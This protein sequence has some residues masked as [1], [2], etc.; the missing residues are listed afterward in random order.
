MVVFGFAKHGTFAQRGPNSI[1]K[2]TSVKRPLQPR[3]IGARLWVWLGLLLPGGCASGPSGDGTNR[4]KPTR[5]LPRIK[6]TEDGRGF[7]AAKSGRVFRPWGVNYGNAGRL[8]EDF[9]DKDWETFAGDFREMRAM[10]FNVV[11]V[12][13]Q[14]GKFMEAPDRPNA[15][16]LKKFTR[17][18]RAETSRKV[19]ATLPS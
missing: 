9:W 12:H 2:L 6:V 3:F 19:P 18:R 16:A 13:L 5:P 17:L 8:M 7:V 14:F 1:P 4:P 10:G 11:R 15:A